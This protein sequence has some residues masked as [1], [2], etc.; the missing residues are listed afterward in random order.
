MTDDQVAVA[1]ELDRIAAEHARLATDA[2]NLANRLR[3]RES[4]GSVVAASFVASC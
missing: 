2:A 1:V 4:E 3:Q